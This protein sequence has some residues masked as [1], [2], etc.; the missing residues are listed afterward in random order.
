MLDDAIRSSHPDSKDEPKRYIRR[1]KRYGVDKRI[2]IFAGDREDSV[3][4]GRCN[5]LSEG[6]FGAVIAGQLPASQIVT[7]EFEL[8][9][10]QGLPFRL[11]AEVRYCRGF[12]HG[13]EFVAPSLEQ[14]MAL[15]DLFAD[16]VQ[17]G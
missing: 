4:N 15:G 9:R 3:L 17:I 13:F 6:G 5:V 10:I 12:D 16:S 14:K 11:R 7:I 2:R 1:F 8:N